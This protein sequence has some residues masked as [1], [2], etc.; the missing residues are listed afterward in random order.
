MG[1][2]RYG[3]KGY[4]GSSMSVRADAAYAVGEKPIS[5]I[6]AADKDYANEILARYAPDVPPLKNL[7]QY[8]ELLK[9]WG[10]TS[11]HHTGKYAKETSFY[12]ICGLFEL[13]N[14]DE[15][16]EDLTEENLKFFR[17]RMNA[18]LR[19]LAEEGAS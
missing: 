9:K 14:P 16:E 18:W 7:A 4:I 15:W 13:Y 3:Q 19:H 17:A 8:K 12:H 1:K 5:K 6:T 11:W 2:V 10:E